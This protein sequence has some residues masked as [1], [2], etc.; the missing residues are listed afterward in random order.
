MKNKG[1]TMTPEKGMIV[2]MGS[3]ELTDS[4][5]RPKPFS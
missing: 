5:R 4:G 2:L 1:F 3:G